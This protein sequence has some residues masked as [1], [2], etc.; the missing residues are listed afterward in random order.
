MSL[1]PDALQITM[2]IFG[3]NILDIFAEGQITLNS[4]LQDKEF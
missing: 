4:Q 2:I 3:I 1:V